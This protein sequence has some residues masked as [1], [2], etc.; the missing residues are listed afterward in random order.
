MR[1]YHVS[2]ACGFVA[3][4][5]I[6]LA[7]CESTPRSVR[8]SDAAT[9]QEKAH[10]EQLAKMSEEDAQA[11][12]ATPQAKPEERKPKRGERRTGQRVIDQPIRR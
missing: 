10:Q 3:A 9:P 1:R 2:K 6:L 11:A 7:G 12:E 5:V 4:V 8:P